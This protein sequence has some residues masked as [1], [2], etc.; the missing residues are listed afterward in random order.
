MNRPRTRLA[1][2][3]A[4]LMA[5]GGVAPVQ[6]Y[7]KLGTDV[8]GRTIS[9]KWPGRATAV[10]Y[11]ITDAG[12]SGV[13][14]AQFRD[15]VTRGFTTWQDV[16]TSS[17]GFEFGGFVSARPLDQDNANV[18]GY[19]N[20]PDLERTLASTSFLIDTRS[21]EILE[22]DI[23]FN[24]SFQWSVAASGEPGRFDVQS[25][26]THEAGHFLG[27]GHS[28]LGETETIPTGGR[29][30]ISAASVMFPIAYASGNIVDRKLQP[31]DIAGASDVYPDGR[32]RQSTGSLQG[33]VTKNGR[34]VFGAHLVGYNLKTG[35]LVGG[36]SLDQDG[37]FAIAG[38][39]PGLY[40]V[41]IEPLDDG[42]LQSF[43]ESSANVDT[44][45]RA[46]FYPR[47]VT[48]PRGGGSARIEIEVAPK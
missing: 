42:D 39:S 24:S 31:D 35:Q 38:L 46:M 12:V 44:N 2:L 22:S 41:R 1:W 48:V 25:I 19:A 26:A 13:S 32:F 16:E 40:V 6:A 17:I 37:G 21:G 33:T 10:R 28:S 7:L 5:A 29:R 3:L 47:L 15:A 11:F 8:N 36:F 43:F 34:G 14:A 18:I 20:R 4:G 30:L 9:L 27:L 23:F 45:F